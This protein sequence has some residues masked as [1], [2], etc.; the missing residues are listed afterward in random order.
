MLQATGHPRCL[1]NP[2]ELGGDMGDPPAPQ[3]AKAT[4][5]EHPS[6]D[7]VHETVDARLEAQNEL[8][9]SYDTKAGFVLGSASLL[10]VGLGGFDKTTFDVLPKL[11][12]KNLLVPELLA[13][14]I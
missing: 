8:I 14:A 2:S 1:A 10:L 4:E 13:W 12:A 3:G 9:R 11:L 6:I 7:L 5:S